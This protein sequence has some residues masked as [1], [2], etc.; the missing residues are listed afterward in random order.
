MLGGERRGG[1]AATAATAKTKQDKLRKQA[2][3]QVVRKK[4]N[5]FGASK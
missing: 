5:P 2:E 3:L 4:L 1:P